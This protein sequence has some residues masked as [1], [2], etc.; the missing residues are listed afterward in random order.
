M[1]TS[2]V[3]LEKA[4]DTLAAMTNFENVGVT[5]INKY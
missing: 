2:T 3:P 5:I 4:S 1:V